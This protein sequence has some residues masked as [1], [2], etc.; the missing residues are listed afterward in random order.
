MLMARGVPVPRAIGETLSD[1]SAESVQASI[2]MAIRSLLGGLNVRCW[3]G[4]GWTAG[5]GVIVVVVVVVVLR[6][7]YSGGGGTAL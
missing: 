4:G 2:S 7:T 5:G 6:G 1:S 3:G